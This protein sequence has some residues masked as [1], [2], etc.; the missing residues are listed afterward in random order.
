MVLYNFK[1]PTINLSTWVLNFRLHN[2][3]SIGLDP[4]SF[5]EHW[6]PRSSQVCA[7]QRWLC[8]WTQLDTAGRA[9]WDQ[10]LHTHHEPWARHSV[11]G[12]KIPHLLQAVVSWGGSSV[13]RWR[14]KTK[15]WGDK[16]RKCILGLHSPG[17]GS[18][19]CHVGVKKFSFS[20]CAQ[21][22][23]VS[24]TPTNLL[25]SRLKMSQRRSTLH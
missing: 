15:E 3:F 19:G 9:P 5:S 20:K 6:V 16:E 17:R 25:V 1:P 23:S 13:R 21:R 22:C 11:K 12:F 4:K 24:L 14:L 8:S 7:W 18:C 2:F 10:D